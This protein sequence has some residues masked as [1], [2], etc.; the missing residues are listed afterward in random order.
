MLFR[1][2]KLR[3]ILDRETATVYQLKM[4]LAEERR[5]TNDKQ[6]MDEAR[7]EALE[8]ENEILKHQL[9]TGG[10]NEGNHRNADIAVILR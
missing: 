10:E 2:Q 1:S 9:R 6:K 8:R 3:S 7:I 4:D 5:R